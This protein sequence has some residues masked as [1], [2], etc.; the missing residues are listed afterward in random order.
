MLRTALGHTLFYYYFV[1]LRSKMYSVMYDAD[2]ANKAVAKGVARSIIKR[3]K[4]EEYRLAI[5]GTEKNELQQKCTAPA[6]RSQRHQLYT[7][8]I[9]KTSLCGYDTK[10]YVLDD[11]VHTLAHG[12]YRITGIVV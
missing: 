11:N 3:L 9:T 10:R 12:H 4:H 5:F 8:N 6:I 1:G 2:G 7:A